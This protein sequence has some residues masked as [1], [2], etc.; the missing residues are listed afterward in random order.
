MTDK[1]KL[2]VVPFVPEA[3][4]RDDA[5]R[6]ILRSVVDGDLKGLVLIVPQQQ[7]FFS[8][9]S[10]K[11]TYILLQLHSQIVL[12]DIYAQFAEEGYDEPND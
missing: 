5:A 7:L 3:A 6:E 8:N 4:Q 12:D 1:P 11:E 10:T 2:T 9:N